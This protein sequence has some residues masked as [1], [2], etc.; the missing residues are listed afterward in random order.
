MSVI[1]LL[2]PR[3]GENYLRPRLVFH[4]NQIAAPSL[5]SAVIRKEE[6]ND[7]RRPKLR[8]RLPTRT[9]TCAYHS[10]SRSWQISHN[11]AAPSSAQFKRQVQN[12]SSKRTECANFTKPG[13]DRRARV[14]IRT[15]LAPAREFLIQTETSDRIRPVQQNPNS[16]RNAI[17]QLLSSRSRSTHSP[18][19]TRRDRELHA[20]TI[21]RGSTPRLRPQRQQQK[22]V[23]KAGQGME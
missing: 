13:I 3:D 23:A 9:R 22:A 4:R 6:R 5:S 12:H 10:P 21:R 15:G 18:G 14:L 2:L 17:P 8:A 16:A 20:H 11:P 1:P 19:H 7:A